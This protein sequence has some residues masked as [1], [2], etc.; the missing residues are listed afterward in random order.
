MGQLLEQQLLDRTW[1]GI[2][3][4]VETPRLPYPLRLARKLRLPES[5]A[6]LLASA[7]SLRGAWL[8]GAFLSLSF[9]TL[10]AYAS[11][12]TTLAPFLLAAPLAP[13]LGVAAAYG[14]RQDPLERLI[15]TAPY[16]RTRLILVRTIAVLVSVLAY[17]PFLYLP[18]FA[19][20]RRLDPALE[21]SAASLGLGPWQVF[22]RVT[23]PQL[24]LAICG[25]ALL[26][27]LHLLSEY[28]LY[29]MIRFETFTTAIVDQF[30]STF[31]GPAGTML[32][33]VLVA[34][35]L[36]LL[37]LESVVRGEERY[38]RVGTGAPRRAAP[39]RLRRLTLP[40]LVL[41]ALTV[42]LALGVPV[43]TIG[44]WLAAGGMEVL[45]LGEV[46]A[47]DTGLPLPLGINVM[48][49]DLGEDLHRMLSRGR[50]ESIDY[51]HAHVDEALDHAMRYSRGIDRETCRRFVLMYVNNYTRQLGDEGRAALTRLFDIAHTRHLIPVRPPV[52]PI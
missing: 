9:A 39:M 18:I 32:A 5:T 19:T 12:G 16:G 41:P 2:R 31:D 52:D 42:L 27:G 6:V 10:A 35:C 22:L 15:A 13:V 1:A 7:A 11:G 3:D 29:A 36:G 37:G 44:R 28:G 43:L 20:L 45:D 33:V 48:R 46:W 30:Q 4:A 8:V 24:R 21:D 40:C 38:A 23:L 25:G 26:V 17:F 14:P 51:A 49:R 47:R 34:C 50:R